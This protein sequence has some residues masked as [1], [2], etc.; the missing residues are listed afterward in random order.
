MQ[1]PEASS[2][3]GMNNPRKTEA[4]QRHLATGR[5]AV[6]VR[7]E[8]FSSPVAVD[9]G[10]Y[11]LVIA[12]E[13]P[14]VALSVKTARAWVDAGACYICTWG[15]DSEQM[16]ESFDYAVILPEYGGRLPFTLLTTAH[17]DEPIEEAHSDDY[18]AA[19]TDSERRIERSGLYNVGGHQ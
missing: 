3:I 18:I 19:A 8:D 1:R 13:K 6:I 9:A 7:V 16:E 5:L 11:V 10:N 12:S 2:G 14:T 4:N 17:N 15:P